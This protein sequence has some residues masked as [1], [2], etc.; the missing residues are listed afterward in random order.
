MN[1]SVITYNRFVLH[2][3]R[4]GMVTEDHAEILHGYLKR[5][6]SVLYLKPSEVTEDSVLSEFVKH[7]N[8]FYMGEMRSKIESSVFN[9][10]RAK[11]KFVIALLKNKAFVDDLE[12]HGYIVKDV[13]PPKQTGF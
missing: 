12:K 5:F 9:C 7:R 13:L 3:E 2:S 8:N 10:D 4:C 6:S 1:T 11:L